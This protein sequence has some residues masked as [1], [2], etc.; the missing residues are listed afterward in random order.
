MKNWE[1]T[2]ISSGALLCNGTRFVTSALMRGSFTFLLEFLPRDLQA[3]GTEVSFIC[4]ST[5][6]LGPVGEIEILSRLFGLGPPYHE[7][8]TSI[9]LVRL[10]IA[11][12]LRILKKHHFLSS[13]FFSLFFSSLIP[14]SARQKSD[15]ALPLSGV[16][17]FDLLPC[18]E[19]P[20]R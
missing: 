18:T 8:F 11:G 12:I 16:C 9:T 6:R 5:S 17:S 13:L 15:L 7:V 2:I 20:Q 3:W 14:K 19:H 10:I 1:K 4:F